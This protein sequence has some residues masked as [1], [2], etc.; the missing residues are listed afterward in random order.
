MKLHL[1]FLALSIVSFGCSE[2]SDGGGSP[3]EPSSDMNMANDMGAATDASVPVATDGSSSVDG[4]VAMPDQGMPNPDQGMPNPDQGMPVDSQACTALCEYLEMCNSC[5]YDEQGECLDVAGCTQVCLAETQPAV[6][7]CV[8]AL[9]TCDEAAFQG[10][11]DASAGDDDCANTCRFLE[12]CN[13]CFTDE[14]GEC[15][16]IAACAVICRDTTPPMAAACIAR[17]DECS[18]IQGCFQ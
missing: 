1:F 18:G 13:E 2:N 16:S 6:A 3:G 10:C 17:L 15:L 12:E 14:D 7:E 11:Y 4:M 9:A 8:S 5:F